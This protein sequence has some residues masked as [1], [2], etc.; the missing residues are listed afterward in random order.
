[1]TIGATS[2][3]IRRLSLLN[4]DEESYKA[5]GNLLQIAE[6][7]FSPSRFANETKNGGPLLSVLCRI[8]IFMV[9]PS[10]KPPTGSTPK[11]L[12]STD[13]IHVIAQTSLPLPRAKTLSIA[14]T[15]RSSKWPWPR[16]KHLQGL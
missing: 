8:S 4:L 11:E 3:K 16:R 10:W 15:P 6:P 5:S 7:V 12:N 13:Y 1:M 9:H 2:Y 14:R